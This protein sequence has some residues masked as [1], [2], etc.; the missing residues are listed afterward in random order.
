MH[1][2]RSIVQ[3]QLIE[4]LGA[5]EVVGG[6]ADVYSKRKEPVRVKFEPERINA[7]LG[8]NLSSEQMLDYLANVELAYDEES[9]EIIAPTFVMTFS[10]T[11]DYR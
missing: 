9:N 10:A 8:T 11:A 4:E 6:M 1:R 7:L 2:Q 3:C 5:G